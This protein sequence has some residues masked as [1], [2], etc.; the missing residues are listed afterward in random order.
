MYCLIY[1]FHIIAWKQKRIIMHTYFLQQVYV[2]REL[3]EYVCNHCIACIMTLVKKCYVDLCNHTNLGY[4]V[5]PL[6]YTLSRAQT[7]SDFCIRNDN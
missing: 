5:C 7:N 2:V 6:V 4:P 3:S 1:G